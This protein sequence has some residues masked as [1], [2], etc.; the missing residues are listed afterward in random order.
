M[1]RV[2][3]RITPAQT[4]TGG[5]PTRGQA[6]DDVFLE[7]LRK[8]SPFQPSN[9]E[10]N[11]HVFISYVH[12]DSLQADRLQ[13]ALEGAGLRVWRDRDDLWLGRDWR[14]DIRHAIAHG[15][16]VFLACFSRRSLARE[17]SYQNEELALA[18]EQL[19][20]RPAGESWLVPVRFD[21]CDIPDLDIGGGRTLA[22][23]QYADLFGDRF[24]E[25]TARLINVIQRI[26]DRQAGGS[27][28]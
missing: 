22:S 20:L 15:A 18:V 19:R 1:H 14:M 11:G 6:S 8:I 24:A 10:R 9:A 28:S 23:I 3:T 2:P 27:L 13:R 26:L 17:R 7:I 5:C 12:E 21:P 4:A 16:L 25:G